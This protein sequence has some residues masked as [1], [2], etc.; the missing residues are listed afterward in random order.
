MSKKEKKLKEK[1]STPKLNYSTMLFFKY[2]TVL[3]SKP[4]ENKISFFYL[5]IIIQGILVFLT[6][7]FKRS[8]L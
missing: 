4:G 1:L 2:R 5:Y 8:L 3:N 7:V 6:Q